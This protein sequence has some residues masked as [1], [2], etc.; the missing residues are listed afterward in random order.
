MKLYIFG[1]KDNTAGMHHLLTE[2]GEILASCYSSDFYSALYSLVTDNKIQ[3]DLWYTRFGKYSITDFNKQ[4]KI[5]REE[6]MNR[7][8]NYYK[9]IKDIE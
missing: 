5:S 9:V 7:N 3:G 6:M 4:T 8:M 2:K 1:P